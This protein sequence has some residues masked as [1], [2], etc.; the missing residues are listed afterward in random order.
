[1]QNPQDEIPQLV[2]MRMGVD[3][4]FMIKARNFA[5]EARPLTVDETTQVTATVLAELGKMPAHLQNSQLEAVLVA[6]ETL[7][8]A[9]TSEPGKYDPK[10]SKLILGR[11][12]PEELQFLYKQWVDGTLVCS[13]AIE[14]MTAEELGALIAEVKKSPDSILTTLS[15]S[16]LCRMVLSLLQNE[17]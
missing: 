10:I 15:R 12:T 3:Y 9:S 13:P 2:K 5:M 6:K 8:L 17:G 4:K 11:L 14:N 7:E 16:Q 1:M